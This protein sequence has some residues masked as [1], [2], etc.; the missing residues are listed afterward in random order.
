MWARPGKKLI[1]MGGEFGQWREW[2]H[3]ESLDWD[4]LELADHRG[5]QALLRDLNRLYREEPALWEA[6]GDPAGFR[7]IDAENADDN[8][9]AF[10]RIAP[11]RGRRLVCVCNFSPVVRNRYR[12]GVPVGGLYREILNT[13]SSRYGGGNVGNAGAAAAEL[14]AHHGLDFSLSLTIPPLAVIWLEVPQF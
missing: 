13:D 7:F 2:N 9:I 1:F 10:M 6:D 4:L 11:Q 5:L 3:D 12:V 14:T 8:V